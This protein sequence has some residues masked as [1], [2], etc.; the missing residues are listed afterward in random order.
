MAIFFENDDGLKNVGLTLTIPLLTTH[1]T[2]V[3][4]AC[5]DNKLN[6]IFFHHTQT[7][8]HTKHRH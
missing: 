1:T 8:H 3:Y 7:Y 5:T 4:L 2:I 6:S